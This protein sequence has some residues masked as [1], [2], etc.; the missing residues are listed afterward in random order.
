LETKALTVEL[1]VK[2]DIDEATAQ[3]NDMPSCWATMGKK[4]AFLHELSSE[5]AGYS[6]EIATGL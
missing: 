6:T 1:E 4:V 2:V 3:A 5:K